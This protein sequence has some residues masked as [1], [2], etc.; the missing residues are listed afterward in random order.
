MA[1]DVRIGQEE[2]E[3]KR[4]ALGRLFSA[5]LRQQRQQDKAKH[6][7]VVARWPQHA[8]GSPCDELDG[9]VGQR[10]TTLHISGNTS[11]VSLIGHSRG[12]EDA[13]AADHNG[14]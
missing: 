6:R 7:E 14:E 13:V 12:G 5:D 2:I 9:G 8:V 1:A 11:P 10:V 4:L 3:T